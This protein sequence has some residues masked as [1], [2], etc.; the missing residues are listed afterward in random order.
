MRV[1]LCQLETTKYKILALKQDLH[2]WYAQLATL[3]CH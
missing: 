2:Y 3:T 1:K